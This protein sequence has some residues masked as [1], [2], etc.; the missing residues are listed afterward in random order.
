[1][2]DTKEFDGKVVFVGNDAAG[3]EAFKDLIKAYGGTL[4]SPPGEE[5]LAVTEDL[6]AAVRQTKLVVVEFSTTKK[7]ATAEVVA[8][9]HAIGHSIPVIGYG[10]AP[11]AYVREPHQMWLPK[12]TALALLLDRD[13]EDARTRYPGVEAI[14]TGNW[15]WDKWWFPKYSREGARK[16]L[17]LEPH[18]FAI[19][20]SGHKLPLFTFPAVVAVHS[21]VY[22]M[23]DADEVSYRV[24]VRPHPKGDSPAISH[25]DC[26]TFSSKNRD[27][28][29]I[30]TYVDPAII[31]EDGAMQGMDMIVGECSTAEVGGGI[32]R[33]PTLSIISLFTENRNPGNFGGPWFW[34]RVAKTSAECDACPNEVRDM[35]QTLK[36]PLGFAPYKRRM[37][38]VF[39]RPERPGIALERMV[40]LMRK[41]IRV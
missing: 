14:A 36:R 24:I 34:S 2:A 21:A 15:T 13:A 30:V 25:H 33:I 27:G 23:P 39:V 31:P 9:G 26:E 11:G 7:R 8:A 37:E 38:E 41:H 22:Y 32:L 16:L 18:E 4:F 17:G 35:I 40:N 19:G 20:I 29:P 6:L 5:L 12:A 3:V 28:R 10:D 1:M